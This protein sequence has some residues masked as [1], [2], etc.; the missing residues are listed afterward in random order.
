MWKS[1]DERAF[2]KAGRWHCVGAQCGLAWLVNAHSQCHAVF[3]IVRMFRVHAARCTAQR[4]AQLST[5]VFAHLKSICRKKRSTWFITAMKSPLTIFTERRHESRKKAL[6]QSFWEA[7]W[8]EPVAMVSASSCGWCCWAGSWLPNSSRWSNAGFQE[9]TGTVPRL[10]VS[11]DFR[12]RCPLH[13]DTRAHTHLQTDKTRLLCGESW[14]SFSRRLTFYVAGSFS[15]R[16]HR[17]K[18]HNVSCLWVE[19]AF[20]TCERN[21]AFDLHRVNGK[22][23]TQGLCGDGL[24]RINANRPCH[25]RGTK[26][27]ITNDLLFDFFWMLLGNGPVSIGSFYRL[28]NHWFTSWFIS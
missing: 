26:C 1:A 4:A 28:I 10:H 27:G 6:G 23:K 17:T 9:H 11:Y 7:R 20:T 12:H 15:T 18:H 16:V 13:A 24:K 14:L 8:K 21:I 2:Q 25:Q 19:T 22:Q 3:D 5:G